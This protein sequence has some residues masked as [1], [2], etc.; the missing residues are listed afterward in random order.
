M[1][2]FRAILRHS[3]FTKP[4]IGLPVQSVK[5]APRVGEFGAHGNRRTRVKSREE[6]RNRSY[7][8]RHLWESR[9]KLTRPY[10]LASDS[11][12]TQGCYITSDIDKAG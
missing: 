4:M 7:G 10:A 2:V 1:K 3:T 5:S 8:I 6:R 9:L 11:G 12:E